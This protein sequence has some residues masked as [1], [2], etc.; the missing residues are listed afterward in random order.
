MLHPHY[1]LIQELAKQLEQHML[2]A[3]TA[4]C[5]KNSIV[6]KACNY[7]YILSLNTIVMTGQEGTV[8]VWQDVQGIGDPQ[9]FPQEIPAVT[10]LAL[11]AGGFSGTAS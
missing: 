1:F 2:Y 3:H 8:W 11:L 5:W 7:Y 10:S 6:I 9:G 4:A